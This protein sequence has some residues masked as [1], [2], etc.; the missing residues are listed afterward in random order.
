MTYSVIG[1]WMLTNPM[2]FTN[3]YDILYWKREIVSSKHSVKD[4]PEMFGQGGYR[5]YLLIF[6]PILLITLLMFETVYHW[7]YDIKANLSTQ[8]GFVQSLSDKNLDAWIYEEMQ[9]R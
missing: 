9:N 3:D 8:L 4:I 7:F 1:F 2:M 5:A 6:M